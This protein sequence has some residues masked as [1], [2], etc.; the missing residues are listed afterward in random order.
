MSKQPFVSKRGP[1][2]LVGMSFYGDPFASASDW[3]TEN[4]IGLLWKRF[5]SYTDASGGMLPD[6]VNESVGYEVHIREEADELTGAYEVFIGVEVSTF[7]RMP[8]GCV[9][10]VFRAREYACFTLIG[11]EITSDWHATV[12]QPWLEKTGA[13]VSAAYTMEVY[14]ERFKGM[15]QLATSEIEVHVPIHFPNRMERGE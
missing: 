12:I 5:I 9:G 1:L 14:D 7:D 2:Y 11:P 8:L 10:K 13:V 3:S 4:E 15:D 6:T